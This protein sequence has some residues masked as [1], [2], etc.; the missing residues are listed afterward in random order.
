M[1]E[2]EPPSNVDRKQRPT[3]GSPVLRPGVS[4]YARLRR[5][6]HAYVDKTGEFAR[7][8]STGE[9]L[10][11]ARPRRFGKTLMLST[12]EC[13][14]QGD[15]PNVR[16][17]FVEFAHP[18]AKVSDELLFADTSWES[19]FAG[20]SRQP[21]IRLDM[22]AVTGDNP[23]K[24]ELSLKQHI[25][26]HA[27]HWY[28][29]GLDPGIELMHLR[30]SMSYPHAPQVMLEQLIQSLKSQ[31]G[32]PVVLVDEYDTP[33]RKLL[34]RDSVEV[35]PFFELFRDFYRLFKQCESDLHKVLI[36]G[37]TRRAY[38]EIFSALNN[39]LDCTWMEEFG[40]ICG[41]TEDDLDQAPL[42]TSI[43]AAAEGLGM[44]IDELR[45]HLRENY[46]G[47]RFDLDGFGLSVYNPWSLCNVLKDLSSP[48]GQARIQ[49]RGFPAHWSDSGVS[50]VLVDAL[51]R[52]PAA[53]DPVPFY[54]P[55]ELDADFYSNR[56]TGLKSLMLQSGYLTHHPAGYGH[57]ARLGWP[58][59]EVARTVL[60]DLARAYVGDELPGIDRLRTCLESGNYRE[61]PSVLLDCLCAFPYNI[62]DDEYSYHAAL[63][64]IFL[65]MGVVPRSERRELSGRYDLAVI[66]RNRA[67]V[68]ELKYNRSL[69]VAQDQADRRQYRRSLQLELNQ[70]EDAVCIALHVTKTKGGQVCIEGAQRPVPD[71]EAAWTPLGPA[72][73]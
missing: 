30:D 14:Y 35:E 10:F 6:G 37:I 28:Q 1:A 36:I 54:D 44:S 23:A 33:L 65:G 53:V 39:L 48:H 24:M 31:S 67:C 47:Y 45:E 25:A 5:D 72:N 19:A 57:P 34:G 3:N 49:R 70:V 58:N 50:K 41:F 46:H 38:G 8:L 60:R 64:G 18:I 11:L 66:C 43:V 68:I 71:V 42:S 59:R 17:P 12:I 61:L 21:V 62:M 51:R 13:M 20:T 16:D 22:S 52:Q 69:K 73:H 7:M 27:L 9:F 32:N 56:A 26:Q 15:R 63:H 29:R 4:D 40:G 2:R 55:D